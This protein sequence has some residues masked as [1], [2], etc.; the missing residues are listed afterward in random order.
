MLFLVKLDD[1]YNYND[2]CDIQ[3]KFLLYLQYSANK[4]HSINFDWDRCS[5]HHC[6][7]YNDY[8]QV[9]ENRKQR[10]RWEYL[11]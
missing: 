3:N 10:F 5:N 2:H 8:Q 7:C 9:K 4:I 11:C 6:H 1:H